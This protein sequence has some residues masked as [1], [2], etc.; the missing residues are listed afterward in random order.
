MYFYSKN[1]ELQSSLNSETKYLWKESQIEI[2]FLAQSSRNLQF[3][4]FILNT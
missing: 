2:P 3:K 4:E 1:E